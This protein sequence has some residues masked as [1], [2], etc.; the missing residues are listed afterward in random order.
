MKT[1]MGAVAALMLLAAPAVFAQDEPLTEA[2]LAL[3]DVN[4]DG[5][6]DV[7][8][9][10]V[11][12]SNAFIALDPDNDDML[13]PED[14]AKIM[15]DKLFKEMDKDADG[16]VSRA[17]YDAQVMLDFHGADTDKNGKLD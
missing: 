5:A 10:R 11:Y 14:T 2:H 12:T 1:T 9:F 4:E 17:E 16:V 13:K 3:L 8:E 6:V 7:T 15:P